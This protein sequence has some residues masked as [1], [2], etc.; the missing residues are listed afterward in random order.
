MTLLRSAARTMLASYFVVSGLKAVRDPESLIPAAEPLVDGVVP[1]I[2]RFA[3]EQ[4]SSYIP[5]D[6]KTWVRINGVLELVGGVALATGKGRRLGA[7]LLALSLVPTTIGKYPFWSRS[8]PAERAADR[9]H[10]LKNLSLLGGVL[11]A[12]RDTEGRPSLGY[13]AQKGGQALVKNTNTLAADTRKASRKVAKETKEL[14][15]A[16]LAEGALLVGAVVGS[17]RKGRKQAAKQ[18]KAAK[19]T[20]SK[21]AVEAKQA[22]AKAA[23]QA[24]KDAGKVAKKTSKDAGKQLEAAKKEAGKQLAAAKKSAQRSTENIQLGEN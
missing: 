11:I 12:S 14:T 5:T 17:T 16:A 21:R 20:A 24:Q 18:L 2:Q 10:F 8:D 19:A 9:D 23:K 22:A 4:V 3:P 13:R 7:G 15:D 6:A 1:Q